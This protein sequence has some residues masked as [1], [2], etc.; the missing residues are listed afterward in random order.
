MKR[1]RFRL[2]KVLHYRSL[3]KDEAK[4]EL[5][6]RT[7]ELRGLEDKVEF[8]ETEYRRNGLK[9]GAIVAASEIYL[10]CSYLARIKEDIEKARNEIVSAKERLKE[11]MTRYIEASKE[12]KALVTL[13]DKKYALYREEVD[14]VDQEFL[15]ELSIQRIGNERLKSK[16]SV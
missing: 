13:K 3:L 15:D 16:E 9:D 8:L 10:S 11:A 1:F 14:R 12:E 7:Q 4:R 2:E 6:L 5:M